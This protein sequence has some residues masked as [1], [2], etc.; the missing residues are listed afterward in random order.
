M[1]C[2]ITLSAFGGCH[3]ADEPADALPRVGVTAS[4]IECAVRD[5]APEQFGIIRLLPPGGCPGHFDVTPRMIDSLR[6]SALLFRF[7]FQGSLDAKLER[8]RAAGLEVVA[9]SPGGGLSIPETYET[10]CKVV[11]EALSARWPARASAF[12]SRLASVRRR[13]GELRDRCRE[14]IAA[15]GL[16]GTKALCSGHQEAFCRWLGLDVAGTFPRG[17]DSRISEYANCIETGRKHRVTTIVANQ[18]EGTRVAEKLSKQLGVRLVVFSN[19]PSMAEDQTTFDQL[20]WA[21]V[22][23]LVGAATSAP[24]TASEPKKAS[25][26]SS[27][28]GDRP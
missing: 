13:L 6:G 1:A 14:Q 11:C 22:E 23:A 25:A 4:Y 10:T 9:V 15:A 27:A 2:V 3:R 19:F 12:A 28:G 24:A 26:A 21:N 18:Q 7:D 20:C 5:L 8:M 16:K 17:E